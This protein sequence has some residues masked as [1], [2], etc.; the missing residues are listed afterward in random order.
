MISCVTALKVLNVSSYSNIFKMQLFPSEQTSPALSGFMQAPAM[1]LVSSV[2]GS[3]TDP[4]RSNNPSRQHRLESTV[5][6][7]RGLW[8]GRRKTPPS[9]KSWHEIKATL[10]GIFPTQGSNSRLLCLLHWQ[11]GSLPLVPPEKP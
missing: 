10:Q 3:A 6:A 5:L 7:S 9:Q 11:A 1:Q 2:S 8:Y 4:S